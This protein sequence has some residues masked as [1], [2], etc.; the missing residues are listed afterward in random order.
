MLLLPLQGEECS[1]P[2]P[3]LLPPN[4]RKEVRHTLVEEDMG[5]GKQGLLVVGRPPLLPGKDTGKGK[6]GLLVV[7]TDMDK[8]TEN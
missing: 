8:Y 6:Q 1:T 3:L 7:G 4:L 5:K 2:L